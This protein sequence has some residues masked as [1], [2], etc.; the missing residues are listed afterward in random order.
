MQLDKSIFSW[1]TYH[2]SIEWRMTAK[3]VELRSGV[4][5][6]PGQPITCRS[7][8]ANYKEHIINS[9]KQYG[10]PVELIVA[11]IAVESGGKAGALRKEPGY[12]NDVATP[13]KV[14]MGLMQTLLSTAREAMRDTRLT[15]EALFKADVSIAAGTAYMAQQA[16]A[17]SFDPP[18]VAAAYNAG[19]V[20]Y[21][22][23]ASNKWRMRCYPIG[24]S[25]HIDRFIMW[26]NDA[27]YVLTG[28]PDIADISIVYPVAI[29]SGTPSLP[30][31]PQ[32]QPEEV[33]VSFWQELWQ[34]IR[35]IFYG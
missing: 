19:G 6:T 20:Y 26:F 28:D 21:N 30:P 8:W 9:A 13:H 35:S 22:S 33:K 34:S 18:K 14:S 27:V 11:T 29:V 4:P 12:V 5:R 31:L 23:S 25:E 15:R 3:G 10:V 7:I 17:T 24:T 2:E 1:H 16:S 32:P